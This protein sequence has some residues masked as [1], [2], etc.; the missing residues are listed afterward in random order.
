MGSS[1]SSRPLV[2]LEA[3]LGMQ[4]QITFLQYLSDVL[5]SVMSM[6]KPQEAYMKV[7]NWGMLSAS[8]LVP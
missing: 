4:N 5:L 7:E 6:Q 1:S 2:F 8:P 3:S